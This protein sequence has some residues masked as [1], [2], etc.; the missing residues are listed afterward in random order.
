MDIKNIKGIGPNILKKLNEN[1]IFTEKDIINTLP[2]SYETFKLGDLN[3]NGVTNIKVIVRELPKITNLKNNVKMINFLVVHNNNNLKVTI[4]NNVFVT[5]ILELGKEVVLVGKY[6]SKFRN[7][8]ASKVYT[9]DSYKEGIEPIYPIDGINNRTYQKIALETLK[10][11]DNTLYDFIPK[12]YLSKYK[13]LNRKD[14]YYLAHNPNSVDDFNQVLRKNKYEELLKFELK[15]QYI[16]KK[17]HDNIKEKKNIN[18]NEV[19]DFVRKLPFALTDDQKKVTREIINDLQDKKCMNRILQGDVGS[20]KTIISIISSFAV[21]K[22]GYQVAVMAPTEILA[23]QHFESFN[24]LLKDEGINVRL[25]TSSTKTKEK[26]E[27]KESLVNGNIDIIIGTHALISDDV[28]FKNLGYVITD[29]QHR[30][31]VEQ[32]KNLRLKGKNPDVLF[33]SA[34]PIPRTLALSL[35]GDMDI[36]TIHTMPSGRKEVLTKVCS[37]SEYD[38]VKRFLHQELKLGHQAYVVCPLIEGDD[39]SQTVESAVI[40]LKDSLVGYNVDILHGKMSSEEKADKLER[41]VNND[42]QVLVSTTVIEVGVNVKNATVMV[43]LDAS[44]FGLSQLHQLRGRVGRNDLQ[45]FCFLVTDEVYVSD[46][47]NV[48]EKTNDGFVISEKDLEIRGPGELLG[49]NQAGVPNFKYASLVK[50][51]RILEC[52]IDDAYNIINSNNPDYEYIVNYTIK[53]LKENNFD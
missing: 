13:L 29:E 38:D 22:A 19:Y 51:K 2:I 16:R 17:N 15:L 1:N 11:V 30:F 9:L 27:I 44:R 8:I 43:V 12:E 25:L 39:E 52:A 14:Q 42:I 24:E 41:F 48:L 36:S 34:T 31:G 32:R 28:V 10:N 3:T 4:F 21:S 35:F 5:K 26:R 18:I 50:D 33:M 7:F 40:E 53:T 23:L 46:R 6:D 20:G 49:K 45:S 37:Y 47:L